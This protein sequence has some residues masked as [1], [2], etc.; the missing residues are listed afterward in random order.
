MAKKNKSLVTLFSKSDTLTFNVSDEFITLLKQVA[1]N[2]GV[3]SGKVFN[4]LVELMIE[5]L[6]R[7]L[8]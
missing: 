2:E 7:K 5:E 6:G 1:K 3:S 4:E 8:D